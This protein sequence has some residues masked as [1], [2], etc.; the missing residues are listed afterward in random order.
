MPYFY[1]ITPLIRLPAS[2]NQEFTYSSKNK[3]E[4]GDLVLINFRRR[5]TRGIITQKISEFKK[6]TYKI[7][8]L[9]QVIE[10]N[11]FREKQIKLFREIA[12]H[13]QASFALLL[14]TAAPQKVISRKKGLF[15]EVARGSFNITQAE[16]AKAKQL[17]NLA[18]EKRNLLFFFKDRFN[19]YCYLIAGTINNGGQVLF[20][21]PDRLLLNTYRLKLESI[22]GAGKIAVLDKEKAQ[23]EYYSNWEEIR[24]GKKQ[25]LL[26]TRS[27]IFANF[28]NLK[29]AIIEEAQDMS[30]KQWDQNPYYDVRFIVEKLP[31]YFDCSV[32]FGT[33]CPNP[34]LYWKFKK[35][36][37]IFK[38][39]SKKRSP[40]KAKVKKQIIDARAKNN[41]DQSSVISEQIIQ[42]VHQVLAKKQTVF[43]G[44]S[45]KGSSGCYFCNN[46][47]YIPKCPRC[48]RN[49]YPTGQGEL[50]CPVCGI[51]IKIPSSCPKCGNR[52][53]KMVGLGNRRLY[54]EMQ[55]LFPQFQSVLIDENEKKSSQEKK[56]RL[57]LT[58]KA[59]IAIGSL[60][61]LRLAKFNSSTGI[62]ISINADKSLF[63]P[64]FTSGENRYQEIARL[65]SEKFSFLLQT[66]YP[67]NKT[68]FNALMENFENFY[69]KELALRKKEKLPPFSKLIKF[70]SREFS[71]KKAKNNLEKLEREIKKNNKKV[72]FFS[73]PYPGYPEKARKKYIYHLAIGCP[74]NLE[75][76]V[77]KKII[78]QEYCLKNKISINI[79]PTG[80]I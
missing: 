63:L 33:F 3:L 76:E 52:L 42:S 40:T 24:N 55:K 59:G 7:K 9:I 17:I 36:K 74:L 2:V 6:Q 72:Y 61:F 19:I 1:K 29:L 65:L 71:A 73:E 75:D 79:E 10:K 58:L 46:C 49:L 51:K 62:I 53:V 14:K 26:G 69:Q 21:V 78:N 64:D 54:Q 16:V 70:S 28:K 4:P 31:D 34:E 38:P 39:D 27:A 18:K 5:K 48:E 60:S 15:G 32:I 20:L 35:Q 57:A 47:G 25:I 56:E 43:M 77:I 68:T 11:Y 67:K 22:F 12:G 13:Y 23:G 50:K 30:F 41:F 8:R 45:Q 44:T 80:L 66:K 37:A